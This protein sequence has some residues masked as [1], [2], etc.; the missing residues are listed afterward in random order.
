MV[1]YVAIQVL[2]YTMTVLNVQEKDFQ[3]AGGVSFWLAA[4]MEGL[5]PQKNKISVRK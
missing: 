5:G 4:K 3:L 1:T 2:D